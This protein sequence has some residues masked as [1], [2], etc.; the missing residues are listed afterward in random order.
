M[1]LVMVTVAAWAL[2]NAT[3]GRRSSR[4]AATSARPAGG[5]PVTASSAGSTSSPALLAGLAGLIVVAINT[6]QRPQSGRADGMELDAIAAVA[7]GGTP[8]T[9]GNATVIGR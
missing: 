9:G 2:R 8:L 1:M 5:V 7:V 6:S 3:F 4:S